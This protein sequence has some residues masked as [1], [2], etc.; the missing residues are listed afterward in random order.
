MMSKEEI[1][2]IVLYCKENNVSFKDRLK[3]LRIAPWRFYAAKSK[4][5]KEV[6][7][8]LLDI[9][10]KGR[11]IACPDLTKKRIHEKK[12]SAPLYSN[13][14][15]EL[16]SANGTIMRIQGELSNSQLESIILSA[17]NHV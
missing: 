13:L 4:Y 2:S 5:S 9:G 7:D 1:A 17:T 11:F 6:K 10:N 16:Q 3:E 14:S 12:G 8:E 15:I